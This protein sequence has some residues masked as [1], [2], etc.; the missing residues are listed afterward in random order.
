MKGKAVGGDEVISL[1]SLPQGLT[2]AVY[3]VLTTLTRIS[4]YLLH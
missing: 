2:V 4:V 3:K 1:Y